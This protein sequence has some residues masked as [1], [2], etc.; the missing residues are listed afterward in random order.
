MIDA[1]TRGNSER[2]AQL[3]MLE[4]Q[5]PVHANIII[6][7]KNFRFIYPNGWTMVKLCECLTS[8][9]LTHRC[10]QTSSVLSTPI[11]V[12]NVWVASRW[13][14][15]SWWRWE[16]LGANWF[17]NHLQIFLARWRCLDNIL[18]I[19]PNRD[20]A[21]FRRLCLPAQKKMLEWGDLGIHAVYRPQ[22]L[23][24]WSPLSGLHLVFVTRNRGDTEENPI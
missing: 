23:T 20:H 3:V 14:V 18:C 4:I 17:S 1:I 10:W 16:H 24:S 5:L 11:D 13:Q 22:P 2:S 7:R 6:E 12:E 9:S 15:D 8:K 21:K 19:V